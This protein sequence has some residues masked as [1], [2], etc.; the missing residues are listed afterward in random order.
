MMGSNRLL[1]L[2]IF[3]LLNLMAADA[4]AAGNRSARTS[5]GPSSYSNLTPTHRNGS[6]AN[7]SKNISA[8]LPGVNRSGG[9]RSR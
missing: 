9:L 2:L 3:C 7:L 5:N 6:L 1:V 4:G 8:A